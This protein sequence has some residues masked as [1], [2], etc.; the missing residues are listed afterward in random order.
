MQ[1]FYSG[2]VERLT[3]LGTDM[4]MPPN[5]TEL[6]NRSFSSFPDFAE[7]QRQF[8]SPLHP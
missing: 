7:T 4:I 2:V 1:P 5:L 6:V 8:F 3:Y